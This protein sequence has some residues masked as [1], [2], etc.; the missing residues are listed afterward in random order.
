[1]RVI[2]VSLHRT[3]ST[4]V[5][6]LAANK[7][8]LTNYGEA[9]MYNT[10]E[11]QNPIPEVNENNWVLKIMGPNLIG[12]SF[13]HSTYNWGDI[14][15]IIFTQRAVASQLASW[16]Y[17]NTVYTNIRPNRDTMTMTEIQNAY[18]TWLGP[19]STSDSIFNG[20][21][22]QFDTFRAVRLDLQ[23]RY[24]TADVSYE[25]CQQ[26]P[27]MA[28]QSLSSALGWDIQE[29]DIYALQADYTQTAPDQKNYSSMITNW[30]E[31]LEKIQEYNIKY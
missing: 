16:L 9:Y 1:M 18:N 4:F 2:V 6:R 20:I 8:N 15:K 23:E 19:V 10:E 5:S 11:S 12:D 27:I 25:M 30:S 26:E 29:E 24:P 31:V 21:K 3:C 13:N 14:D 28:A 17:V 7:F 22:L